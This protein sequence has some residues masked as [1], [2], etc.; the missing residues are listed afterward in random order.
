MRTHC[1]GI[2]AILFIALTLSCSSA[3][4]STGEALVVKNDAAD[5]TRLA[6]SFFFA[7]QY[8]SA[9]QYYGSALEANLSVDN[10]AGSLSSRNALGRTYLA[11]GRLEDASRELTDAL[12]DARAAGLKPAMALSLSNLGELAYA[13]G[14]LD[15]AERLFLE[16]VPF[17][18]ERDVSAAV[19]LHNRAV[20]ALARGQ[21]EQAEQF[22]REAA[23]LNERAKRWVELGT[24]R[25]VLAAVFRARGNI[26]DAL[27]WANLALDADK[28]AENT[29]GIG[30]D[31]E[32]LAK[33]HIAA[34]KSSVAFDLYR[35]AFGLWLSVDRE[36]EAI[37]CL[38]ALLALAVELG[39]EDY[40]RR[41]QAI[42]DGIADSSTAP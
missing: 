32:A 27:V 39:K 8:A 14:M 24:N 37:R 25:Y 3:P 4:K 18:T 33:L 7:G 19:L 22:L 12:E 41:Y 30:A 40:A 10:I 16:A 26:E 34:R 20:V 31:L 6:D 17:A 11:L 28:F 5:F 9:L 1:V 29:L 38:K 2:A 21:L 42:L 35:R 23:G 15:E 36:T 13:R